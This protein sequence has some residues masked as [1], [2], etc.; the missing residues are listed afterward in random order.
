VTTSLVDG[1]SRTIGESKLT[2]GPFSYGLWR[3]TTPDVN[4]AQAIIETALGAG[5]NLIDTAD[6]YGFDWGGSGFGTVE[7]LLGKVLTQAPTLRDQMVLATKGGIKP[8]VPYDSSPEGLRYA[9]EESL[10]RLGVDV[11]DLYQIHRHDMFTHPAA[12]AATLTALRDEAKIRE[13]GVSN[14]TSAQIAAL[15]AHLPFA[16]ATNQPEFSAAVTTPIRDGTF[17]HAMEHGLVPMAWA[18][19]AGGRLATGADVSPD[20][21]AVLDRLAE[22][23]EVDR[24]IIALAFVLAHP[25]RPV[26]IVG[27]QTPERITGSLAALGVTLDRTD[28]YDIV[29]ASEGAPLP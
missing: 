16:I 12:V 2:V 13:V 4:K 21:L 5:I 23:E 19:L 15:Q 11:I 7:D 8:P 24:S 27:T 28:V 1:S 9:C 18:P 6:V 22:R 10:R 14:H 29:A 17:D 26:C 25:S 3:F 20:L